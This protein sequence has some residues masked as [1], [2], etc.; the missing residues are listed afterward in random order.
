MKKRLLTILSLS[1]VLVGASAFI[2]KKYSTGIAGA[3]GSPGESTCTQCHAASTAVSGTSI[4]ATPAFSGNQYVPGQTYTIQIGVGSLS[5]SNFGFACEILDAAN[6]NAGVMQNAG[7]GVQFLNALNA[8]KSATHTAKKAGTGFATFQFE[9]VAPA[10]G[11]VKIYAAGNAVNNNGNSAGDAVSTSTLALT[12]STGASVSEN[13]SQFASINIYPNPIKSDFKFNYS[14]M[15]SGVV[16]VA[17]YDLQGK[18]IAEFVNE[19]QI[20]GLH[21]VN[22]SIPADLSKGVY[23]MKFTLNGQPAAQRLVI[24]Q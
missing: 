10:S 6:A 17:L 3:A 20:N 1:A 11:Q 23:M 18:E 15:E 19:N 7:A 14:L 24:T 8:R 22:A 4:I 21:T 13:V 9:W 16:R 2:A 5:L 12:A